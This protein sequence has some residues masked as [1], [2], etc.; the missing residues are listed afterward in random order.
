MFVNY[1]KLQPMTCFWDVN[2]EKLKLIIFCVCVNY[3]KLIPSIY[4][5]FYVNYEKLQP[6]INISVCKLLEVTVFC[7]NYEELKL[8]I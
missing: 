1:E 7:V 3:G 2:Y 8:I 5:L 6:G 4:I